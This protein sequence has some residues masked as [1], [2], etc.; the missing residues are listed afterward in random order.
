MR[1]STPPIGIVWTSR[2]GAA[3]AGGFGG[4]VWR[5]APRTYVSV[6]PRSAIARIQSSF[7]RIDEVT[8]GMNPPESVRGESMSVDGE[9]VE[10]DHGI[11]LGPEADLPGTFE[12]LILRV[13]DLVAVVPDDEVVARGLH[14]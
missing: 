12:R 10:L 9:V 5:P 4:V 11:G 7:D 14:L 13:E 2:S 3:P 6:S 8:L 1:P